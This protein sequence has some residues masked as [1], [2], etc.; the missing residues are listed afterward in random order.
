MFTWPK[1]GFRTEE[2]I[3]QS[4]NLSTILLCCRNLSVTEFV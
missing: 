1:M 3:L 4:C 2:S